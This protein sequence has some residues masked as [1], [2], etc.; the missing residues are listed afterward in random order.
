MKSKGFGDTLA[1]IFKFFK[2]D[3]LVKKIISIF[4]VKDCGC[5]RRQSKLNKLFPYKK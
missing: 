3:I 5:T 1:N 4:G 2:I